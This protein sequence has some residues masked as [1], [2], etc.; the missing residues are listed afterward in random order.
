MLREIQFLHFGELEYEEAINLQIK[1]F[2][3][4]YTQTILGKVIILE[5]KPVI[6]L[7]RRVSLIDLKDNEL[8]AKGYTLQKTDRGGE[9]TLHQPGQ[10][11]F[12]PILNIRALKLTVKNYICLLLKAT[13]DALKQSGVDCEV[14]N[15]KPGVYTRKGKIGFIGVRVDRGV[16]RHGVSINF[17]NSLTD[18]SFIT[19]CGVENQ[20]LDRVVDTV[21]DLSKLQFTQS[22]KAEFL[23]QLNLDLH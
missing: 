20:K 3:E 4:V 23:K 9:V 13:R 22:W 2:E 5:H 11:V 19:S 6:T 12:Y 17:N 16:T 18:F 7:G 21:K 14:N 1:T 10:L 8:L 15:D